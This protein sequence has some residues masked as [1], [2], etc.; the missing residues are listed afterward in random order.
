MVT[1][2]STSLKSKRLPSE[3]PNGLAVAENAVVREAVEADHVVRMVETMTGRDVHD[4]RLS[5]QNLETPVRRTG[6]PVEDSRDLSD[7]FDRTDEHGH[8]QQER[9]KCPR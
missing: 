1:R 9:D 7:H 6:G 5:V 8:V 4:V 2:R 3:W